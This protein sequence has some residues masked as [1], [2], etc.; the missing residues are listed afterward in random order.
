LK[1]SGEQRF[2]KLKKSEYFSNVLEGENVFIAAGCSIGDNGFG[3][4]RNETGFIVPYIRR[5]HPYKVILED[6]VEVAS[7][8]SIDRGRHRDTIVGRG[9]KIDHH[10][11][12]GHNAIIGK[13]CLLCAHA[14]I[15]GSCEI[16]DGCH[17]WMSA[18]IIDHVK[19]ANNVTIGAGSLV[20][21]DITE[22]N[23]TWAG[24]PAT[25]LR[26]KQVY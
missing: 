13:H 19:I 20:L 17:I 6:N 23:T 5:P 1:S 26:D 22:P 9:T 18:T 10:V 4:E 2:S 8:V 16:G 15:G 11:H 25:K 7:L 14:N 24:N 21:H 3:F 12:I